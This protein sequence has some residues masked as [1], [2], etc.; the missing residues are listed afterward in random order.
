MP[1][2]SDTLPNAAQFV[3]LSDAVNVLVALSVPVTAVFPAIASPAAAVI[4][5]VAPFTVMLMSVS[6]RR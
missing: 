5:F 6:K 1:L 2:L 3:A 4:V